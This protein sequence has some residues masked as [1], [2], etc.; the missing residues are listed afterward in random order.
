MQVRDLPAGLMPATSDELLFQG[1][2]VAPIRELVAA[3]LDPGHTRVVM[4]C[5]GR[6]ATAVTAASRHPGI[7]ID[8]SDLSLLSSLIGYLADPTLDPRQL[9]V[10]VPERYQPAMPE[11]DDPVAWTAGVMV[12]L[13]LAMLAGGNVHTATIRT[14][15]WANRDAYRER[16]ARGLVDTVN[17]LGDTSYQIADV[18]DV[19]ADFAATATAADAMFLAPPTYVG[20]YTKM[21]GAAEARLWPAGSTLAVAEFTPG[22]LPGLLDTVT[23]HPGLVLVYA[24]GGMPVPGD[25]VR[26]GAVDTGGGRVDYLV[27][28]HDTGQRRTF[29]TFA[30]PAGLWPVYTDDHAITPDSDLRFVLVDTH[31]AAHYRD[32]FVHR[33]AGSG[34]VD[35]CGLFLIDG[36]VVT[37]FGLATRDVLTTEERSISLT[38]GVTITSKR[39]ARLG[40]L[41]MLC[42]TSTDF[43]TWLL[44]QK[45]YLQG[46]NPAGIA[47]T[48]LTTHHEGKI[49]RGVLRVIRRRPSPGDGR[50]PHRGYLVRQAADF[51][52]ESWAATLTRWCAKW[53]QVHRADYKETGDDIPDADATVRAGDDRQEAAGDVP[54]EHETEPV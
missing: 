4:P 26:I 52:D 23:D 44:A 53:G 17:I 41:F 25:W 18:R 7:R 30:K 29:S 46:M 21:Y 27:A 50:R 28:N 54:G 9:E 38:Y 14:E 36:R 8:A 47:T 31:T 5:V 39:Y 37:A 16:I 12:A 48:N 2:T 32:L 51:R 6:W 11:G 13:K 42:I 49:D 33:L 34:T 19:I 1:V 35:A 10:T 40:K 43:R 20:G 22:E 24:T 3:Q 45:H 15:V